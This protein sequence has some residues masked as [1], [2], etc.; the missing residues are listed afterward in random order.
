M[1]VYLRSDLLHSIET[2]DLNGKRLALISA[3]KHT[4]KSF[5]VIW[6]ELGKSGRDEWGSDYSNFRTFVSFSGVT[7][8][9]DVEFPKKVCRPPYN[10]CSTANA[11]VFV[12]VHVYIY[13]YTCI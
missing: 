11:C 5:L 9:A 12:Y 1:Y 6:E 13:M 8:W 2:R 10:L 7:T 4:F 3:L